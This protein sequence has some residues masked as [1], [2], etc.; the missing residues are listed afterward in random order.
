MGRKRKNFTIPQVT[1]EK[2]A[3][4][5]KCIAR[6]DG[7][8]VFV[9]DVA[10]GDIVDLEVYKK[11]K[12][13]LEARPTAFH[14]YSEVRNEPVCEHFGIC[15]GCKWQHIQ[16][17]YQADYKAQHVIDCFRRI[18]KF[19]FPEPLPLLKPAQTE[20]YRNK[21]EFTFSNNR[22][23]TREEIE[24]GKNFNN[25]ALGFHIPG[26]FD[27]ILQL[28]KCHLQSDL[29]NEIRNWLYN[30]AIDNS[31]TFYDIKEHHG[32]L[33]N[34][35]IRNS[36]TGQ[37]M[38]I[39]QFGESDELQI[40]QVM[41][42]LADQFPQISSLHYIINTK[43]NDSYTDQEVVLFAGK[44]HIV[45]KMDDLEFI[46]SPKSFYQT[47]SLQAKALYQVAKDF[48]EFKGDEITYDLYTGTGT[49][50]NFVARS[51]SKV[52]GIEY[53][54]DAITDAIQNSAINSITN[55]KF[56]AGD[57]KDMLTAPFIAEH[58]HPQIVITDPPRA[59]M[60][61]SVI[62]T[63]LEIAPQKIVYVSCNPATQA[64]DIA[65]LSEGYTVG[66]VQPVDMF[67][68]TAHVENVVQLIKK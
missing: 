41:T 3:D 57:M 67:P 23:L 59:G 53:V 17:Q 38:V 46:I 10:P 55:T 52:I 5:G 43:A 49:I 42:A 65:L 48:C 8:A 51:T 12:S 15:G 58:G 13:F 4:D 50:A 64:R 24:S 63:L 2:M 45:E 30:F 47:N 26:R 33:R 6:H 18:G 37:Y 20:F 22:W 21:L 29:S 31:L 39:V 54:E 32:L 25:N 35:I 34:L 14:H 61:G 40:N 7:M 60:H 16:Y 27:K 11:K 66:K 9:K 28:N 68:H 19:E 62:Q 44:N 1:I 36:T 56:F